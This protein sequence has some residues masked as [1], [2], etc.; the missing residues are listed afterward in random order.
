MHEIFL[1][2]K[3]SACMDYRLSMDGV[4]V[5]VFGQS[6]MRIEHPT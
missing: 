6:L 5:V 3:E 2:E 1:P 4:L